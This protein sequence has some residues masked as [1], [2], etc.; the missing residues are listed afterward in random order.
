[1]RAWGQGVKT[2]EG[3]EFMGHKE[4]PHAAPAGAL[5]SE[6]DLNTPFNV[7][8]IQYIHLYMVARC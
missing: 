3:V 7:T 8:H 5:R 2:R 4:G 1:M 6:R